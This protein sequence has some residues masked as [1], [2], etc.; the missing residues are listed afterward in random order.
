MAQSRGPHTP[1][2]G[3]E[4]RW[5][6]QAFALVLRSPAILAVHLCAFL[7]AGVASDAV[8][9]QGIV[10]VLT[11]CAITI[12][13]L[14]AHGLATWLIARADGRC[15]VD[16]NTLVAR[17]KPLIV[18]AFLSMFAFMAV[19][20]MLTNLFPSAPADPEAAAQAAQ[21]TGL[22]RIMGLGMMIESGVYL[23]LSIVSMLW[24]PSIASLE[25]SLSEARHVQH[26]VF[27]MPMAIWITMMVVVIHSVSFF[28]AIHPIAGLLALCLRDAWFYVAA[29]EIIGGLDDNG[30]PAH[31]TALQTS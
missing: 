25:M 20:V 21:A 28:A 16:L 13:P 4:K 8:Q 27:E 18:V 31:D 7:F 19:G 23:G 26:R 17:L 9:G 10:T 5:I 6:T 15:D 14:L 29:R 11:L 3:W 1:K 12:F 2:H 30:H 24:L 22:H